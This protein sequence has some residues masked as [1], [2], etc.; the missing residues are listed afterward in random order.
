MNMNMNMNM[1]ISGSGYGG[2][3]V[4]CYH[5]SCLTAYHPY[6]GFI[7]GISMAS[8]VD[9]KGFSH[10]S[11]LCR[12]H[13]SSSSSSSSSKSGSKGT[14]RMQDKD[15]DSGHKDEEGKEGK[16]GKGADIR[17]RNPGNRPVSED[18]P[19][20][21]LDSPM[22]GLQDTAIKGSRSAALR[23]SESS[24]LGIASNGNTPSAQQG[25]KR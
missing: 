2:A 21:S 18:S 4:Q 11:I 5:G 7:N 13:D 12:K 24:G 22:D 23:R 1:N 25:R 16:E 10:Y 8:A 17:G 6:C 19:K 14:S 3:C 9:R 15:K 20:E